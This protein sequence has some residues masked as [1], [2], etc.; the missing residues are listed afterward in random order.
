MKI[1]ESIKNTV[2]GSQKNDLEFTLE[3]KRRV[4]N[5]LSNLSTAKERYQLF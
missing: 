3:E 4:L 1:L 2:L 5:E